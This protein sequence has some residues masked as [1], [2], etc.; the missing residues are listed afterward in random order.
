MG[1]AYK[2]DVDD[3][4]ESPTFE[5][6]D[7]FTE[8]GATVDYYDP[9]VPVIGPTREHSEWE[10]K[11]SAEW[12]EET[13]RSYD[14]IVISTNHRSVDLQSLSQWASLILDCRN[15]MKGILGSATIVK[16]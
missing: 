12:T 4:R 2:P 5:L 1:I 6:L 11:K 16:T 15:A 13:I 9:H 3:M 10:G 14:A 8:L 7:R